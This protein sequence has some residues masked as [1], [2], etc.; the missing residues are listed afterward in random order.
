LSGSGLVVRDLYIAQRGAVGGTAA[1]GHSF[2]HM[3]AN[4]SES[5][6]VQ[7]FSDSEITKFSDRLVGDVVHL[8]T[9]TTKMR[10]EYG[11]T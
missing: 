10:V 6:P 1:S 11:T 4:Y 5:V 3:T 2:G 7:H 8:D 9:L